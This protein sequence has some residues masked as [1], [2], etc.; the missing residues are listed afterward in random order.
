MTTDHIPDARGKVPA[1]VGPVQHGVSQHTPGPWCVDKSAAYSVDRGHV[2]ISA[3][4]HTALAQVVVRMVDDDEPLPS[5]V[6]NA[7]LIAAAPELLAALREVLEFQSAPAGPTIHDF[8]RWR[9]L[10]DGAG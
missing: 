10:A 7:R 6:A 1:V 9:R 3:N 8:G 2:A 5:G 4:Q